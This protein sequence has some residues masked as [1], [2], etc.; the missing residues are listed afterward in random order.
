MIKLS[1]ISL[2]A[3]INNNF[4]TILA[5]LGCMIIMFAVVAI[6]QLANGEIYQYGSIGQEDQNMVIHNGERYFNIV[7]IQG[8]GKFMTL[9]N[10]VAELQKEIDQ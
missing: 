10:F 1:N 5:L 2:T 3:T 7:M 4:Y 8:D 6:F 9:D